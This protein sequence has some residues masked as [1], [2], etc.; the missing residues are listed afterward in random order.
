LDDGVEMPKAD[1]KLKKKFTTHDNMKTLIVEKANN[2]Q[3]VA[4]EIEKQLKETRETA[5]QIA[6]NKK[7][8]EGLFPLKI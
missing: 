3:T 8:E 7:E 5:D 6:K 2:G 1:H 4:E